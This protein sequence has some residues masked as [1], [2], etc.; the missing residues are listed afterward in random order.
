MLPPYPGGV[1]SAFA[2]QA[3]EGPVP[4]LPP[5]PLQ[6]PPVEAVEAT[7]AL[8]MPLFDEQD[9]Y[10]QPQQAQ[11]PYGQ[12]YGSPQQPTFEQ[13]YGA[14]PPYAGPDYGDGAA[15]DQQPQGAPEHDSDYDHLFRQDVPSPP[16]MRPHIIQPPDRQ[17]Q[18]AQGQ[19]YG[20]P[21]GGYDPAYGYGD[22]DTGPA[23]G[24]K[25][26][27]KVLIGIVVAGCVV[28]GLVVGGLL[29][30]GGSASAD[31]TGDKSSAAPGTPTT[32][33]AGSGTGDDAAKQQAQSLD[34]LLKTSGS[35]RSA[36]VNAV[37]SIKNCQNLDGA[38][39]DL[40]SAQTQ[41]TGLVTRLHTLSL[42]KL[43]G[44]SDLTDAL[45]KAWQAS[46]AADGHYANWAQ[47]AKNNK[48]VCKDGHARSTEEEGAGNRESGVATEQKKR[49]VRLW[50]TI[51][52]QYGLTQRTYA[53]L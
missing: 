8:A 28:A 11:Q 37:A 33:A 4:P 49:A 43:P 25:M 14:P 36:V 2:Q 18:A 24:R 40:R 9:P 17:Q 35:S 27:P 26:S 30:S 48:K 16:S 53:Q 46:A 22:D 31:N 3:G 10:A 34:A 12:P 13:V 41:R 23:G 50:N 20:A 29:N 39:N 21:P 1:P 32:A 42:D 19:P 15:Y 6:Q 51:A 52:R 44:N 45:T 38:A 5:L 7:Q 47:E